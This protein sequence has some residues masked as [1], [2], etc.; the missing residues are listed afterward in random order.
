MRYP[1]RMSFSN[2]LSK[3]LILIWLSLVL[4]AA[5]LIAGCNTASEGSIQLGKSNAGH[6]STASQSSTPHAGHTGHS[7][8]AS[9]TPR[10]PAFF[11]SAGAAKP[12]PA[13]IDPSQFRDPV[14]SKAYYLAKL[15][16]ELFAQQPCYCYCDAGHGHRS[17][18]DCYA[19]DHSA[20]CMLCI[21]EGY[22]TDKMHKEGKSASEIR[23]MIVRGDWQNIKLE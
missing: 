19:S 3:R 14:I 10:I 12:L 1:I 23:D 4:L 20:G 15:N 8:S 2:C 16:P 9:P 11:E 18:L 22:F 17:L 21:K 6:S 13:V 5:L 7:A